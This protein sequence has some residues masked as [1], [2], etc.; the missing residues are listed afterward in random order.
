MKSFQK[1][2][3]VSLMIF[4]IVL[5]KVTA[6]EKVEVKMI[7]GGDK[8]SGIETEKSLDDK[9]SEALEEYMARQ[10]KHTLGHSEI[11]KN[12][13]E[14]I[15]PPDVKKEDHPF[16]KNSDLSNNSDSPL[17]QENQEFKE[18]KKESPSTFELIINGKKYKTLKE[19]KM[20]RFKN[21]LKETFFQADI[22]FE[23][24]TDEELMEIIKDIRKSDGTVKQDSFAEMK[25]M[26]DIYNKKNPEESPI[27]VDLNKM[28]TIIIKPEA[29]KVN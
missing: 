1:I 14:I 3:F 15:Y 16:L 10:K 24:F 8:T 13:I 6:E 29:E 20:E 7:K 11:N 25:K 19:Y 5:G 27:A 23:N 4:F 2:F 9:V 28:K 26:I 17:D 22:P 12:A 21:F 18:T